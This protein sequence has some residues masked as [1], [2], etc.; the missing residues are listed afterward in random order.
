MFLKVYSNCWKGSS[1][2]HR[3]HQS[4]YPLIRQLTDPLLLGLPWL[5]LFFYARLAAA[6]KQCRTL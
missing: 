1:G 6:E 2:F 4:R 3:L 5:D